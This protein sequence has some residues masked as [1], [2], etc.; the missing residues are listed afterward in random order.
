MLSWKTLIK[1]KKKKIKGN[2]KNT[3][4]KIAAGAEIYL[5]GEQL[6]REKCSWPSKPD[7]TFTKPATLQGCR[8]EV[9]EGKN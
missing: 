4:L 8:K 3:R 7:F 1:K 5:G 2:G 6:E 9:E